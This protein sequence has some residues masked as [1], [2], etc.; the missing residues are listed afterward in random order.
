[1]TWRSLGSSAAAFPRASLIRL[2]KPDLR[3]FQIA[4]RSMAI[5]ALAGTA[6]LTPGF[7]SGPTFQSLLTTV[8]FVGC[9]AIGMTLITMSGNILSLGLGAMVGASALVTIA[10]ANQVGWAISVAVALLFGGLLGT[11]QGALIG[12]LRANPI[13]VSIASSVLI[14]AAAQP[15]TGNGAF[16]ANT[17][18]P[19]LLRNLHLGGIPFEFVVFVAVLAICQLLLSFTVFGRNVVMVGDSFRASRASGIRSAATIVGAYFAAG[20]FSSVAGVLLALRYER[21]SMEF[22]LGYDYSAIAAVL[23][24][25]TSVAGGQGSAVRTFVG[26]MVIGIVQVVLLLH[27]LRQEWQ[28]LV[29]GII[30]LGVIMLNGVRKT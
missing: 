13:I 23:V 24:G 30:V 1:V 25:G 9:V 27:G 19:G 22:G 14:Y 8:S 16:Y 18:P 6:V 3:Q 15:I 10:C 12:A 26:M 20:M 21:A 7:L 5:V 2:R 28:Y 17:Q 29:T 11:A 4:L